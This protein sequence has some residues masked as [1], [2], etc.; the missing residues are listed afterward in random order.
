VP[1]WS[2]SLVK[3]A[4][5]GT[6]IFYR[7]TGGWG[8]GSAFTNRYA[9][10]E[11]DAAMRLAAAR[12]A[13][14]A[15]AAAAALAAMTPEEI[16]AADKLG[17]LPAA[18]A[19]SVDSFQRSVLRR[20]EPM[21]GSA[22]T[23]LLASQAGSGEKAASA[24]MRW[25]LAGEAAAPKAAPLGSKAAPPLSKPVPPLGANATPPGKKA[26]APAAEEAKAAAPAEAYGPAAN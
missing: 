4:V 14:G 19:G 25:A 1:Y 23:A 5:V 16:A 13:D 9:G 22:V 7:W 15:A 11:P 18:E 21:P 24:S 20:Y 12:K 10:I 17:V 8:T 3:A 26:E 6:H 2:S